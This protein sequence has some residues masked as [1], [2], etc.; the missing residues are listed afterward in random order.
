RRWEGM[1]MPS[2]LVRLRTCTVATIMLASS[3]IA[4]PVMVEMS[5]VRSEIDARTGRPVLNMGIK[6]P[7]TLVLSDVT[8]T[9]VGQAC[10]VTVTSRYVG[11]EMTI[12]LNGTAIMSPVI[13]EPI[14]GGSIQISDG[15]WTEEETKS[16][17][18]QLSAPDATVELD[19]AG[20]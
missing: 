4:E 16:L 18:S 2:K 3:S 8:L 6:M 10:R 19:I 15:S 12:L 20:E 11:K 9:R 17:A 5:Y 7:P 13:R 1:V 14:M